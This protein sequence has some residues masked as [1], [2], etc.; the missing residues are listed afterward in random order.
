MT[1]LA[2]P[3]QQ[4]PATPAPPPKA[5]ITRPFPDF[6]FLPP[7]SQYSGPVFHLSQ[8]YPATLPASR[9]A[10][11]KT[12]FK[13][14][15]KR[16]M[17]EVRDYCLEGNAET[18]WRVEQN[19]TR[20]WY[21]MP[22]QHWGPLAREGIHGLTKE[23]PVQ[24]HQLAETQSYGAGQ[25]YAVAIY[26]DIAGY[27]I[28]QVWNRDDPAGSFT[29]TRFTDGATVCKAL[30][31]DLGSDSLTSQVPSLSNPLL[32]EGYVTKTFADS[33]RSRRNIA[34]LQLDI[35][36]SDARSPTG[37]VM[38]TFQYNGDLNNTNKW[39]NLVPLGLMWGNDEGVTADDYTNPTPKK[40]RINPA[41]KDTVINAA[42]ELPTTH[43]GWNGRLNGPLDNPR[44]S[45][46]SCHMTAEYPRVRNISPL[47]EP[48]VSERYTDL[49]QVGDAT[50]MQWFQTPK[51]GAVFDPANPADPTR[52]PRSTD[53]VLQLSASLQALEDWQYQDGNFASDWAS[54]TPGSRPPIKH[55]APPVLRNALPP[56][57]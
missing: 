14:D 34:L 57:P 17:T 49:K 22:F 31:V 35:M 44:S 23:A 9:P 8:D 51:P 18:D 45:C 11:M 55:Q 13:A 2:T 25:A 39:L 21:H 37:W 43:L 5:R 4:T 19:K 3:M 54:P 36:I 15:W 48:S 56:K 33:Q 29:G 16:Y 42:A 32:W 52:P 24:A 10:F 26:N 38:G 6:Q 41:L 50:W 40:T 28:G 53:F 12:D 7:P 1:V 46:I 47:F 20:G 30:F 27:T